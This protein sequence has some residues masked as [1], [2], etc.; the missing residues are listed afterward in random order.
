MT[1]LDSEDVGAFREE[2]RRFIVEHFDPAA[3]GGQ[4][5]AGETIAQAR[6][7]EKLGEDTTWKRRRVQI[8]ALALRA[9][10]AEA[11]GAVADH[12][13]AS[14]QSHREHG[15]AANPRTAL[16]TARVIVW[17]AVAAS[18]S[19]AGLGL[20]QARLGQAQPGVVALQA[21]E[22]LAAPGVAEP[23]DSTQISIAP[24]AEPP[25]GR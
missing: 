11:D 9:L 4:F 7:L 3:A 24:L 21:G 19:G 17:T 12:G 15:P 6:F 22:T 16:V 18:A 20:Y 5:P 10:N 14:R 1:S 13:G 23:A 8:A 25:G 2:V